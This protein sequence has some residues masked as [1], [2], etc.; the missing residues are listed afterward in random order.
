MEIYFLIVSAGV[1]AGIIWS[2][3][4]KFKN[5]KLLDPTKLSVLVELAR[6]AVSAAETAGYGEGM[7]GDD[8]YRLASEGLTELAARAGFNL[9][10]REAG[11]LIHAVLSEI[12][13]SNTEAA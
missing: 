10:E 9:S 11:V 2:E 6:V 7:S 12:A 4:C 1:V 8:K 5:R 3:V 13:P